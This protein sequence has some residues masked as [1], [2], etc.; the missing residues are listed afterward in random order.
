MVSPAVDEAASSTKL[1]EEFE[2]VAV[3]A[4]AAAAAVVAAVA[5]EGVADADAAGV[6]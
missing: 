4:V 5:A 1:Y 6:R 2:F 3:A